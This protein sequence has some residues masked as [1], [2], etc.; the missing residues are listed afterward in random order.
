MRMLR[1]MAA[2]A[3]ERIGA[4]RLVG[5]APAAVL[6]WMLI[7]S[8]AWAQQGT[9]Q[10]NGSGGPFSGP[11]QASASGQT[12][13]STPTAPSVVPTPGQDDGERGRPSLSMENMDKLRNLDRQKKIVDD[14]SKLLSLA[15]ELKT[16]VDKSSENTLSLEVIRKADEIEKL[17]R[18]VKERMKGS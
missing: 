15:N 2:S 4:G 3:G 10:R 14:T 18:S 17:A 12:T 1:R 8:A 6:A 5:V 16:D 7:G 11:S 9:G 13:P